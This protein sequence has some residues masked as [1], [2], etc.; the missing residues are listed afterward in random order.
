MPLAKRE[1]KVNSL[2]DYLFLFDCKDT[3][4]E[5]VYACEHSGDTAI[6]LVGVPADETEVRTVRGKKHYVCKFRNSDGNLWLEIVGIE[7]MGHFPD[8]TLGI[9]A[10]EFLRRFRRDQETGRIEVIEAQPPAFTKDPGAFD[11]DRY[12]HDYGCR[13]HGYN[14][15]WDGRGASNGI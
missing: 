4:P 7:S 11:R 6:R 12:L 8:S 5:E 1:Y 14:T 10:W 2:R 15:A 3:I 9:G 13:E